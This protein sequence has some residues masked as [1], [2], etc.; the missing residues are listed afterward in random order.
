M[1]DLEEVLSYFFPVPVPG[2]S[3][4]SELPSC[5]L[6]DFLKLVLVSLLNFRWELV[7]DVPPSIDLS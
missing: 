2:T 1:F 7:S 3:K 5:L 4:S 6:N